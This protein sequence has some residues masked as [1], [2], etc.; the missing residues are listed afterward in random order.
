MYKGK[1]EVPRMKETQHLER[2]LRS[3][4]STSFGTNEMI[5][6]ILKIVMED[7]DSILTE[8]QTSVLDPRSERYHSQTSYLF[9]M[10]ERNS[11][12]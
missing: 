6:R 10:R 9:S 5:E 2:E 1:I 11:K 7:R 12:T 4:I 3:A 8:I